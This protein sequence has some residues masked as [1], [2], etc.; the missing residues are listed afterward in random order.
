MAKLSQTVAPRSRSSSAGTL[1]VDECFSRAAR[2]ASLPAPAS[3]T[4]TSSNFP[5]P[6]AWWTASQARSDQD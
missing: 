3:S 5:A 6:T 1:P 2:F 4:Q